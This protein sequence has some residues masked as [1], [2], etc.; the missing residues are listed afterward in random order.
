MTEPEPRALEQRLAEE[1]P[2]LRAF[3]E[4]LGRGSLP[5]VEAEDVVQDAA[6]RA[7]RYLQSFDAQRALRPWLRAVA[8]RT[9]LDRREA[10]RR[11]H[12][13]REDFAESTD[14]QEDRAESAVDDR[15]HVARLVS[16]LSQVEREVLLRF[17]QQGQALKEIAR[18]LRMPENTVKSHLHRARRKLGTEQP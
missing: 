17:H 7:L 12:E 18:A 11:E 16:G 10:L 5:R 4:R 15:D 8:L 14:A 3:V 6:E 13:R 2:G 9:F 1:L